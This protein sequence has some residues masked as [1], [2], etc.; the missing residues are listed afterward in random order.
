MLLLT[1]TSDRILL[2]T[3]SS[4]AIEV[5][6]SYVDNQSGSVTPGRKNTSISSATTTV[7]VEPPADSIQRNVRTLYIKNE[8]ATSN[9]LTVNHDNGTLISTIWQG[10]LQAEEELILAQDGTWRVY[11]AIGLEKIGRAHV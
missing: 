9:T 5:H 7:I 2:D 4:A 6:A 1:S 8:G 11:D 3:S 10:A